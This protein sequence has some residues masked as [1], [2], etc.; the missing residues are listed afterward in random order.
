MGFP[1]GMNLKIVYDVY[2]KYQTEYHKRVPK[3]DP[4]EYNKKLEKQK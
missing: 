4:N 1:P 2:Q 3:K